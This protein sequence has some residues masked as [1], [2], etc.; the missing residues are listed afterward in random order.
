MGAAISGIRLRDMTDFGLISVLPVTA[1][2]L[3]AL[4]TVSF[5]LALRERP[6][7]PWVAFSHV[8]VLIVILYGVTAFLEP[9]PRIASVYRHVGIIDNLPDH[10]GRLDGRST[11]TSA[12]R[13]SSASARC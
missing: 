8:F 12:G 10:H 2:A 11:P 13:A 6:L 5:C 1:L 3:L 4:L 9:E 7:P